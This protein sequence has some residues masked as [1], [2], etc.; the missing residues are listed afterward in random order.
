MTLRNYFKSGIEALAVGLSISP[1]QSLSSVSMQSNKRSG[2]ADKLLEE[3]YLELSTGSKTL[4]S[5]AQG[6]W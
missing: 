3:I 5:L 4:E 6:A 2:S 1:V